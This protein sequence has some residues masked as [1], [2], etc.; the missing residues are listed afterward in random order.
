MKNNS[1]VSI[2]TVTNNDIFINNI[3]EN[4]SRQKHGKKE[5]ILVLNKNSLEKSK[6]EKIAKK[7]SN[8]KIIKLDEKVSLG[9]CL[10]YA[11]KI[12]SNNILAK[13]DNDDYYGPKYLSDSLQ[14]FEIIDADVI[15]KR[16]HLVY[17]ENNK[18]LAIRNPNHENKYDSFVNGSSLMFKKNVFKKVKFANISIAE[19]TQF[20]NDCIKKGI[21]I[22]STN[23][24]HHVY[25]RRSSKKYHAWKIND[26]DFLKNSCKVIGQIEDYKNY[27]DRG[28]F[29]EMDN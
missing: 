11:V 21:K 28:N 8:V 20:C 3:F 24:F 10:N 15:G 23:R 16:S 13:F 25:M 7:H 5:L 17:F 4:Y 22:Y 2:I 18:I 27:A 14:S 9:Q 6:Y 1:G 26:H 29:C 19:D 12:S